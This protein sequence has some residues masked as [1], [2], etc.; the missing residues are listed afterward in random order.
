MREM[1]L[2]VLEGRDH[3]LKHG[4]YCSRQPNDDERREGITQAGARSAE[5]EFF[6]TTAPWSTSNAKNRLG[7]SN[8]IKAVSDLLP[9]MIKELYVSLAFLTSRLV[10]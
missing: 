6:E 8:L 4:Y 2:D 9:A 3:Q 7:T 5:I 1:W 10:Y